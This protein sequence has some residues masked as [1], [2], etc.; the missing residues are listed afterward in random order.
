MK[1]AIFKEMAE[2]FSEPALT[3][4]LPIEKTVYTGEDK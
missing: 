2:N 1:K 4:T 3:M